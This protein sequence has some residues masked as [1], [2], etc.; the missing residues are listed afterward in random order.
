MKFSTRAAGIVTLIAIA[1]ATATAQVPPEIAAQLRQI[2]TGVCVPETAK[3]Y[4]PLQQHAPYAGVTVVRD[5]SYAP[6]PRTIMDVFTPEKGGGNRPVLIYVS[7][8]G[9]DKKVNGPDG[10]AFY[11]NIM[12]WALK[13]GMTGVN[14]QRRGGL[15]GGGLA[16][17]EPAKDVGRVVDWVRANIKMY[18]GNPDR[19][20]LWADSAGNGPVSTYAAH[21][22]IQGANG[23]AVKGIV[24]MSPPNF[25]ILP[26]TVQAPARG[27]APDASGRGA[28]ST[29]CGRPAGEARGGAPR[30]GGGGAPGGAGRGGQ[31][32]GGGA[33][34]PPVDA[35]TQ[36][37]RSNLPGLAKGK[38][39]VFLGWG[40]IDSANIWVFDEALKNALCKA[41]RC[42]TSAV[43]KDHSHVSLVFSP[44]TRD[45]SVTGPILKWMKSIK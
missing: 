1:A 39:A 7:G 33:A 45:D 28:L 17:D 38:I 25:N 44:N 14:M 13:N 21:P 16:W 42:P 29:T 5:I 40:E 36:L 4:A 9:G 3:I 2:G 15:G 32:G 26:E 37:A 24:L 41:G 20:F 35:A 27:A 6:D 12:L 43:F 19:I 18:K 10:D 8:G 30:G 11:D 34:Q 31:G 22:E 23:A